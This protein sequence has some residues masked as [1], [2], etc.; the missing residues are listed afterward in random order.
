MLQRAEHTAE[1]SLEDCEHRGRIATRPKC[2]KVTVSSSERKRNDKNQKL[3]KING[4]VVLS[5]GWTLT[6]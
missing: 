5:S 2:L 4:N 6:G 1:E 3:R